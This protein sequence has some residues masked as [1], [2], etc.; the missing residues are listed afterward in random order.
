MKLLELFY[1]KNKETNKHTYYKTEY[2]SPTENF[3][4]VNKYVTVNSV[5]T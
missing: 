2:L 3:K 5:N 1:Y 4:E